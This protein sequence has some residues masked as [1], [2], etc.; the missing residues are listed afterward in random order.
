MDAMKTRRLKKADF[1]VDFF[2]MVNL[3]LFPL[4]GEP[5][6]VSNMLAGALKQCQHVFHMVSLA[7]YRQWNSA[8]RHS[9]DR[10]P[11]N[12]SVIEASPNTGSTDLT[13]KNDAL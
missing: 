9:I 2:F 5:E 7:D 10:H 11:D 1:E 12:H 8:T 13:S 4:S 6:T 3:E